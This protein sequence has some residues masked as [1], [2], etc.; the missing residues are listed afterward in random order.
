MQHQRARRAAFA[1]QAHDSEAYLTIYFGI[2]ACDDYIRV[3]IARDLHAHPELCA[4]DARLTRPLKRLSWYQAATIAV[5]GHWLH[6]YSQHTEVD[7]AMKM[8]HDPNATV[9]IE[10]I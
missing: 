6:I 9:P 3:Q 2:P 8:R 1:T 4:P 10:R 7:P 5:F